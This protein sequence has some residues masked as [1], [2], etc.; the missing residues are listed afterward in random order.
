MNQF[1]R[2]YAFLND[3]N[4]SIIN[5]LKVNRQQIINRDFIVIPESGNEFLRPLEL[6]FDERDM[7]R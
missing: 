5:T 1:I 4:R 7:Q 6:I 2:Q 3:Y